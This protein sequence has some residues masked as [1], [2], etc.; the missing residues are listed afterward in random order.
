MPFYNSS[1]GGRGQQ[2]PIHVDFRPAQQCQIYI[3][4]MSHR[5]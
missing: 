1:T 4:L 2:I 5:H 3:R